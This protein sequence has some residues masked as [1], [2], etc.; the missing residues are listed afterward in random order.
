MRGGDVGDAGE[1][2]LGHGHG[3]AADRLT[4]GVLGGEVRQRRLVVEPGEQLPEVRV[5]GPTGGVTADVALC[6]Q[7]LHPAHVPLRLLADSS[8]VSRRR[9]IVFGEQLSHEEILTQPVEDD[10][11]VGEDEGRDRWACQPG[12]AQQW[13]RAQVE[14]GAAVGSDARLHLLQ[15]QPL[16]DGHRRVRAVFDDLAVGAVIADDEAGAQ[17]CV[18]LAEPQQRRLKPFGLQPAGCDIEHLL[19]DV[20]VP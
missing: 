3:S 18:A 15:R 6:G 10:V 1:L 4:V 8:R 11:V 5:G 9:S 7:Q 16:S 14:G 2:R 17:D 13:C 20:A 19:D 12:Q